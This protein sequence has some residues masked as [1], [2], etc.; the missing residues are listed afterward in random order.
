MLKAAS[1][2]ADIW[3]A[4]VDDNGLLLVMLTFTGIVLAVVGIGIYC[5]AMWSKRDK[6][7]RMRDVNTAANLK[8]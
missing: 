4:K 2:L 6:A 3:P 5:F 1:L 7:K 8:R